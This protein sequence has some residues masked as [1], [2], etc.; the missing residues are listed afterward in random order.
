[1]RSDA[2]VVAVDGGLVVHFD[3]VGLNKSQG[4]SLIELRFE[5][6]RGNEGQ[7]CIEIQVKAG[8]S[9]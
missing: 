9:Y 7:R 6:E 8:T 1:V 4:S 5:G 3:H 2:L